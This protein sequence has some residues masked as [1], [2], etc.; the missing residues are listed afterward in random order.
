[1]YFT[2][3]N[4]R[5][6]NKN[7]ISVSVS[8]SVSVKH[9]LELSKY[10]ESLISIC[11]Q[12]GETCFP[13]VRHKENSVPY[14]NEEVQSLKDKVLLWHDIWQQC[15]KPSDGVVA[16]IMRR[17]CHKYHYTLRSIKVTNKSQCCK[18]MYELMFSNLNYF[19]LHF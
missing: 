15:G 2:F 18:I 19:K 1:M 6:D 9:I 16:Q 3:V 13:K 10:C 12:S 11:V 8:V 4:I 17:A 5:G 7:I 14:W